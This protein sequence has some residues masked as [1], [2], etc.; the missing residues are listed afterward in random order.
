M[1]NS[2][3]AKLLEA[4]SKGDLEDVKGML[5]SCCLSSKSK[6]KRKLNYLSRQDKYDL[7]MEAI[8]K[9][10]LEIVRL[11]I[12]SGLNFVNNQHVKSPTTTPL[13][14]A[15]KSSG[16]EMFKLLLTNGADIGAVDEE[17]RTPLCLA[18]K[19]D[20]IELVKVIL[21][22]YKNDRWELRRIGRHQSK[23]GTALQEA[24][25]N[26]NKENIK[27]LLENC[28]LSFQEL[29][30]A[31][32]QGRMYVI[33]HYIDYAYSKDNSAAGTLVSIMLDV[34]ITNGHVNVAEHLLNTRKIDLNKEDYCDE[35]PLKKAIECSQENM[36]NY[37]MDRGADYK[38]E[39][40]LCAAVIC[41]QI[42][43]LEK[44]FKLSSTIDVNFR[45]AIRDN[46][47]LLHIAADYQ[48][49]EIVKILLENGALVDATSYLNHTSLHSA[50][51]S[52]S[53]EIVEILLD[54]GA[55]INARREAH[56]WYIEKA[57][58][59]HIAAKNNHCEMLKLLLSRG[60]DVTIVSRTMTPL[61]CAV[62]FGSQ[63]IV[64]LLL[65]DGVFHGDSRR[66][67]MSSAISHAVERNKLEMVEFL[68]NTGVA[69]KVIEG[70]VT[71]NAA[72][73]LS[74][75]KGYLK[76]FKVF[77]T[78]VLANGGNVDDYDEE[79]MTPLHHVVKNGF[80]RFIPTMKN[81]KKPY[82]VRCDD[83]EREEMI[84]TLLANGADINAR[85]V[86]GMTPLHHSVINT[87]DSGAAVF[88]I[89]QGADFNAEDEDGSS[90]IDYCRINE[91]REDGFGVNEYRVIDTI[92]QLAKDLL[93][94]IVLRVHI[95]NAYLSPNVLREIKKNKELT[96]F[97]DRCVKETE[98]LKREKFSKSNVSLADIIRTK[99]MNQLVA[100][101]GNQIIVQYFQAGY[102]KLK[103][104]V[105][106]G[107]IQDHFAPALLRRDLLDHQNVKEFFNFLPGGNDAVPLPNL[108]A[109]FTKE[110][111]TCLSNEDLENMKK[112]S[113]FVKV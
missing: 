87:K 80:K 3:K 36:I 112:V 71:R 61:D 76:I 68:L 81:Y 90:I 19:L 96:K 108:P 107:A 59:L 91:E 27:F 42:K 104:I 73:H 62:V 26:D 46:Q 8:D 56:Y 23:H 53:I 77:L 75:A 79:L 24:I 5:K 12:S 89:K 65:N 10:Q 105:Y 45:V 9:N 51:E 16:I 110:V 49:V 64:G 39:S 6:K 17:E 113:R 37:L 48:R 40:I 21:E 31:I 69:L 33:D 47:T 4:V 34:A 99:N 30:E 55:S 50:V 58:P 14:V 95:E 111:F 38:N 32:K 7:F 88:L 18:A 29:Q 85:D 106:S 11:F 63:E 92:I 70:V 43:F 41:N 86:A 2:S 22:P 57:T 97:Y 100:Y 74:A 35:L 54:H 78:A 102:F 20:K 52:G 15:I 13:H 101:A 25:R 72:L 109:T 82:Y 98:K 83:K 94:E 66:C 60:A 28:Q 93:K 67:L 44:V 103:F 84:E 1:A